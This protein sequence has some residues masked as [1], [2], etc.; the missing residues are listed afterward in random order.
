MLHKE[1]GKGVVERYDGGKVEVLFDNPAVGRKSLFV[2]A[3][4]ERELLTR[5]I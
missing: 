4:I 3:I 5:A 2:Q 1:W